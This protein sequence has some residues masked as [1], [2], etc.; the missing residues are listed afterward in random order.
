LLIA[1]WSATG[2]SG[3]SVFTAAC[4]VVLAREPRGS[5]AGGVRVADL[6]GDLPAVLGLAADPEIGLADWLD[7]GPTAPTEALDRLLVEVVPGLALLPRG[8]GGE[9]GSGGPA[10][11]E[12]GAALAAA[13]AHDGRVVVLVDC[14]TARTPALRAVVEVADASVV[15]VRECY[16][17]LRRA[18]HSPL[19]GHTAG[20]VL[21]EE[22]GRALSAPEVGEVLDLPVLA[23]VPVRDA[24]ARAVDA[25]VLTSRLPDALGRPATD[26]LRQVGVLPGRRGAAA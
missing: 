11:S 17:A 21:L 3:T 5:S 19:L 22:P 8:R 18:V 2:G 16:L 7:A 9:A 20:I 15:V 14:G 12:S 10:P 13:L 4:S 25:G 23:R 6:A 24:V 1:L 26:L